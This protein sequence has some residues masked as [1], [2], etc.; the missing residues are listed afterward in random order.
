MPT[1]LEVPEVKDLDIERYLDGIETIDGWFSPD[2]AL[3][4]LAYAQLAESVQS[5]GDVLEIGVHHGLSAILVAALRGE[6]R[7]LVA[8]DL[9]EELQDHNVSRSGEGSKS[10]FFGNMARFFP[11]TGFV[12]EIA[13]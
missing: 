7:R 10:L 2:A 4:F 11:N 3:L 8:I 6:G 1:L 13:A 5:P 9:F 12:R